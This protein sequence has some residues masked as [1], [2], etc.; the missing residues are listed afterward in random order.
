MLKTVVLI[1]RHTYGKEDKQLQRQ[2]DFPRIASCNRPIYGIPL[3]DWYV[4]DTSC[5]GEKDTTFH[6][7]WQ[8][9]HSQ[10]FF[11]NGLR[12]SCF[13]CKLILFK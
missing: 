12:N 10:A 9:E 1:P 5:D 13:N 11:E 3:G 6:Y 8:C 7:L 4:T 2:E